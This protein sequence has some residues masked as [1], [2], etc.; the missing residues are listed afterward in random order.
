MS[1]YT[2]MNKGN[3]INAIKKDEEDENIEILSLT[4]QNI[5]V[6]DD[7]RN[8]CYTF[9]DNINLKYL[10]DKIIISNK[11]CY[12][13][14]MNKS[15]IAKKLMSVLSL[16][17]FITLNKIYIIYNQYDISKFVKDT[18]LCD[19][20]K[21]YFNEFYS[22][23]CGLMVYENQCVL[24]NFRVIE[25][26]AR[27][28]SFDYYDFKKELSIGFWSTLFHELRHQLLENNMYLPEDIYPINDTSEESVEDFGNM[29]AERHYIMI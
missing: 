16:D 20:C 3:L 22:N 29:M 26:L 23:Q 13:Y 25:K 27:K 11:L 7:C 21:D 28:L 5:V 9:P 18:D 4:N 17:Y 15:D 10:E 6:F 8:I 14:K 19:E 12:K 2:N 1:N 24:I